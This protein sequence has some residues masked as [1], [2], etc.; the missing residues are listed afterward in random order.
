MITEDKRFLISYNGEIY[1]FIELRDELIKLG[2]VFKSKSDTEVVL[3]SLNGGM[4]QLKN[5]MACLL[6]LFMMIKN[7]FY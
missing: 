1:N 4:K 5:L 7:S 6:L 2:Y 3:Y